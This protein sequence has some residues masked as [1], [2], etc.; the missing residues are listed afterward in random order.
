M[1][2]LKLEK[3]GL[4]EMSQDEMSKIEGG[5]WGIVFWAIAGFLTGIGMFASE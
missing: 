1:E 3:S 2:K 4:V 5:F